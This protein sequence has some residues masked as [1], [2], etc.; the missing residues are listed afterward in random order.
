VSAIRRYGGAV[1]RRLGFRR[2]APASGQAFTDAVCVRYGLQPG[3]PAPNETVQ[4]WL[5]FSLSSVDR[6]RYAVAAMGGPSVFRGARVLDVGCAYGGF[7][8]AASEAG[9]RLL[10]GIDVNDELLKLARLQL[11]DYRVS[12][13]LDRLDIT[14]PDVVDKLGRFDVILCNDV[15]EHVVDPQ[16]AAVHLAELLDEGGSLFLQIPNG[17]AVEFMLKDGHYGLF[18]ITLLDRSRAERVWAESYSDTYGVEH[19]A[20]LAYYVDIFSQAG[21]A[22]RLLNRPPDDL[23]AHIQD[24]NRQFDEL[25][26]A[27]AALSHDELGPDLIEEM[28][29]RGR[30][31]IEAFRHQVGLYRA[32]VLGAERNIVARSLWSTYG[33]TFWEL[34][35]HKRG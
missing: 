2:P 10:A 28:Q 16:T 6:G 7:L 22:L 12:A 14:A 32:S 9:A 23:E 30:H 34:V 35:G 26:S 4:M 19:Y 8:V 11:A 18:G 21:L 24:L 17:K 1:L 15:L 25:E 3:D 27:L 13:A 29:R 20:P 5:D 31:E 33:L